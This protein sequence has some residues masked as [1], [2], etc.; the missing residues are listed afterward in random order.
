MPENG[1]EWGGGDAILIAGGFSVTD[2]LHNRQF[3]GNQ[4]YVQA[5]QGVPTLSVEHT[6][7]ARVESPR[8]ECSRQV[9]WAA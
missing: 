7:L 2:S 3:V 4:D 8:T 6:T 5:V 1:N 9:F